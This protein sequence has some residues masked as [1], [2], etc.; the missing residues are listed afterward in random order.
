MARSSYNF[1]DV[2]ADEARGY[3]Q[4]RPRDSY[5]DSLARRRQLIEAQN[6]SY[7]DRGRPYQNAARLAPYS[8]VRLHQMY[9]KHHT[10]H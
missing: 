2:G 1:I 4:P 3:R 8:E 5:S 6:Y 10:M 7:I 9:L